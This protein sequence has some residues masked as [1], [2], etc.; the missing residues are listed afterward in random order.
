M[1]ASYPTSAK[2]FT[3]KSNGGTIDASH[4][5]DLQLEVTAIETDL[6]AGLPVARGGTGALTHTSGSVLIGAGTSAITSTTTPSVDGVVFPATQV[7]SAGANTLD[8]Y[9]EGTFT[10]TDGSGAG[11]SLTSVEGRYVKLGQLVGYGF[12]VTYP[13]TADGTAARLNGFPF[14]VSGTIAL[15]GAGPAY[16]D[17]G[18]MLMLNLQPAGTHGLMYRLDGTSVTNANLSA[19]TIR[20]SGIYRATA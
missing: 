5:N 16:T 4:V 19:N 17:D 9:E 11:L 12:T 6:I 3:T 7:A 13:V 10:P 14:T 2:T 15:F 18:T 20:F 1:P 8:D